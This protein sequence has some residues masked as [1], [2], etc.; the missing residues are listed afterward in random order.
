[1]GIASKGL[2]LSFWT[3]VSLGCN[4]DTTASKSDL[5]AS[6]SATAL[7][8]ASVAGPCQ[9][10]A[11]EKCYEQ[12]REYRDGTGTSV[13]DGKRAA[14]FFRAACDVGWADGCNALGELLYWGEGLDKNREE[15][16]RLVRAACD[17]GSAMGCFNTASLHASGDGLAKDEAKATD[18]HAQAVNLQEKECRAGSAGECLAVARQYRDGWLGHAPEGKKAEEL[19]TKTAELAQPACAAGS[20][21]ACNELGILTLTG[22]GVPK[23]PKQAIAL[24]EK[25]CSGGEFEACANLSGIAIDGDYGTRKDAVRAATLCE[26]PCEKGNARC[27]FLLGLARSTEGPAHDPPKAANAYERGCARRNAAACT[28]L[29]VMHEN[30]EGN[31]PRDVVKAVALYERGCDHGSSQ[32]CKNAE[33]TRQRLKREEA[34]NAFRNSL[35]VGDDSHCGLVIEVKPPIAR[36]QTMIGEIWLKVEQL[37]PRGTQ[38][39]RFHNGVY[40]D[41]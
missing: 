36:I 31:L 28:N 23:N 34:T 24:Y 38:S 32:S 14:E 19:F 12:G 21:Q 41:P 9:G 11:P 35:K 15:A 3:L 10:L 7:P 5:G 40:V 2:K 27:C 29:G 18:A 1:M 6:T 17:S 20:A 30:G 26:A 33:D 13:P 22:D 8:T 25:A 16:G 37:H 39:C 4:L